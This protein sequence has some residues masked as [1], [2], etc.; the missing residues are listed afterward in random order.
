M[1]ALWILAALAVLP[2]AACA[3]QASLIPVAEATCGDLLAK[4][5]RKT[6]GM[7]FVGCT[8][9]PEGQGKPLVARY[10]VKGRD[11]ASV[12]AYFIRTVGLQR[13]RRSCCQWDAPMASFDL[14][15]GAYLLTMSSEET[16]ID[17]RA[18]WGE[19]Q[20]FGVEVRLLIEE[21]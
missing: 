21:V 15:G 6:A 9:R 7:T 4:V 18:R 3:H 17:S 16:T 2:R 14:K 12:E 10:S 8:A 5:G 11:A 19:I 1:R 13:L 20:Q